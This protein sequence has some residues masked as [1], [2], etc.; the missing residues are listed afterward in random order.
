MSL[1]I[2]A[3]GTNLHAVQSNACPLMR[4]KRT[5][6]GRRFWSVHDPFDKSVNRT[7]FSTLPISPARKSRARLR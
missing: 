5:R 7:L 4:P 2:S 6:H 1:A 3:I